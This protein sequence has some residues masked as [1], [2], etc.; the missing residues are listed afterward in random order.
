MYF[1][2]AGEVE[3]ELPDRTKITLPQGSFFGELALL[4][5]SVRTATVVTKTDA[6]LL[7]LDLVDFRTLTARHPELAAAIDAEAKR[8]IQDN[9]ERG[10]V[11]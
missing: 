9:L 7:V 2:A 3:L 11:R 1:I 5:N 10:T 8:R 4:T 6:A